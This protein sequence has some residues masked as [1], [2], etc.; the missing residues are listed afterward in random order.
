MTS[1]GAKI[2]AKGHGGARSGAGRKPSH[3]WSSVRTDYEAGSMSIAEVARHHGVPEASL[4]S[5]AAAHGWQRTP[6]HI[7]ATELRAAGAGLL[8]ARWRR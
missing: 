1:E 6:K 5:H 8:A 7:T 4:R 3:D 2:K